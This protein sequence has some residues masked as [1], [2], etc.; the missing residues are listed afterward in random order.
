MTGFEGI[1]VVLLGA[2]AWLWF[3]SFKAREAG[4]HAARAACAGENFQL[5]DDT[6]ALASL[7]LA[8]NDQGRIALR[9]VYDFEFSETGDNRRRGSVVLLGHRV[10]VVNIGLWL[11]S[12]ARTLH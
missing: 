7:R 8:R 12:S 2:L 3:D 1:S 11:V 10:V 6:V 5:L 4:I 9:R